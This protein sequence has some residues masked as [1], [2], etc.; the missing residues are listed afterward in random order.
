MK[1]ILIADDNP[2][3]A[4]GLSWAL[5]ACS[6]DWRIMTALDGREALEILK[7]EPVD[8]MLTDLQMPVVDGYSLLA[9]VRRYHPSLPA[10]AMTAHYGDEARR[11]LRAIGVTQAIEKPFSIRGLAA[12]IAAMLDEK[13][14]CKESSAFAV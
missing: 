12:K 10:I 1:N 11:R 5:A 14:S 9:Y 2:L 7:V 13:S 4:K 8:F 3:I 6:R